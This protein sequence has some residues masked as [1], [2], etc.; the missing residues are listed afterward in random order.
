MI[1]NIVAQSDL[2]ND[3]LKAELT[4]IFSKLTDDV[5]LKAVVDMNDPKGQEL[6][7]FLATIQTL[8]EKITLQ[9]YDSSEDGADELDRTYLPVVGVYKKDVYSGLCFHGVPGG[10]EINPFVL[11]IYNV[12]GPGQELPK[13]IL[14]YVCRSLVPIA[15][16][17][18]LFANA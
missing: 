7:G 1:Q 5:V 17:R 10:K 14:K 9:A 4:K 3:A 2:I 13:S 15:L 12:G 6:A 8:S 16:R 18:L 11:S